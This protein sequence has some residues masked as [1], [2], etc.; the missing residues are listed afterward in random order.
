MSIR[1]CLEESTY[2]V[3]VLAHQ[4]DLD[5]VINIDPD[6]PYTI[7]RQFDLSV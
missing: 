4:K 7:V 5:L 2:M 6:V 3:A 1:E